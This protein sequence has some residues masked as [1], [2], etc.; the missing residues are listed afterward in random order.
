[1]EA[2]L[3]VSI[4]VA[5]IAAIASFAAARS[6]A[7]SA[8]RSQ[9]SAE[10][11]NGVNQRIAALDRDAEELREAYKNVASAWSTARGPAGAVALA[12]ELEVLRACRASDDRLAAEAATLADFVG[13]GVQT[14]NSVGFGKVV[15]DLRSAYRHCQDVVAEQ[16][17]DF[18][19]R[20]LGALDGWTDRILHRFG[21]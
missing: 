6:S 20:D 11:V 16:R 10:R 5:V 12:A 18:F 19:T 3:Y 8:A 14:G 2:G 7:S 9:R 17:E 15:D 21:R 13:R 4:A 1:M